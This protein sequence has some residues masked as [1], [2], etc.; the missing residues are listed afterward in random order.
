MGC[1]FEF[2]AWERSKSMQGI[3]ERRD[4]IKTSKDLADFANFLSEE[5][6]NDDEFRERFLC[7]SLE[8]MAAWM[9]DRPNEVPEQ[10]DWKF[11]GRLLTAALFYD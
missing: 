2:E 3:S 8:G 4:R 1:P 11:V 7:S 10:P 6:M 9:E 5:I